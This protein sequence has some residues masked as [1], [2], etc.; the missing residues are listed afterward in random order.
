MDL[1]NDELVV[2]KDRAHMMVK[3]PAATGDLMITNKRIAFVA[4]SGSTFFQ[5]STSSDLWDIAIERVMDIDMQEMSGLDHP[6]IRIRYNE[7]EM[8]FTLPDSSP[9]SSLAAMRLFVNSARRIEGELDIIRGVSRSLKEDTLVTGDRLPALIKGVPQPADQVCF[10]CGKNLDEPGGV[11]D[12]DDT[13]SCTVC[14]P[15]MA[16]HEH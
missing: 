4:K 9:R 7:D 1:R 2:W 12:L 10:Q 14:D 11:Q 3:G 6:V 15:E 5:R 16:K 13:S 8:F